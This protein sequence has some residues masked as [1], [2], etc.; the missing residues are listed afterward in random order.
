MALEEHMKKSTRSGAN[1]GC[2]EAGYLDRQH[3]EVAIGDTKNPGGPRLVVTTA[4]FADL[5]SRVK[6]GSL[7]NR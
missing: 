6:D 5:L 4:A 1:G 2:V 3:E 7:D